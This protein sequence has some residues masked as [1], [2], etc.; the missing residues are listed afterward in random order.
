MASTLAASPY[1]G[2]WAGGTP[3][4]DLNMKQ[5]FGLGLALILG[6]LFLNR[7]INHEKLTHLPLVNPADGFELIDR[8]RRQHFVRNSKSLMTKGEAQNAG[9]P[10]RLMTDAGELVVLPPGMADEIRNDPSLSFTNATAQDFHA[11]IPGFEPF[12]SNTSADELTQNVSRK[13]LTKHLS[14]SCPNYC[15]CLHVDNRTDRASLYSQKH[16]LDM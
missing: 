12:A 7:F 14:M 16:Q 11:H 4:L 5:A 10:F 2:S 6:T 13:Q 15:L 3:A 1:A 8:A 9:Q